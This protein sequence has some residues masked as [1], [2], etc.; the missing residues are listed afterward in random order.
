MDIREELSSRAT[1]YFN[2]IEELK[3]QIPSALLVD[4][5]IEKF[6]Q[7]RNYPDSFTADK[8][9]ADME[10]HISTMAMAVV[11]LY[12]KKGAEGE[13]QHNE[14]NVNHVYENAYISSSVFSDVLPFVK[15]LS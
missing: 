7:H 9:Q 8:V 1:E 11:D 6:K 2:G 3:G 4:F 10:T 15:V 14:N 5:V 12:M 13:K